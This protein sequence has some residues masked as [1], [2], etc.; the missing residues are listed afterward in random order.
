MLIEGEGQTFGNLGNAYWALG[1]YEK[2]IEYHQRN[3]EIARAIGDVTVR[4]GR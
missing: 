2:V 4:E 1:D 3:L